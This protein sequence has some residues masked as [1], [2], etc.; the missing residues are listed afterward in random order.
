MRIKNRGP[1]D[2]DNGD[3]DDRP[4]EHEKEDDQSTD[5][6]DLD[7]GPY[8]EETD[9]ENGRVTLDDLEAEELEA[10]ETN[11]SATI[12]VDE[13]SEIKALRRD[14]MAL[15]MD[16]TGRRRDEFVCLACFLVLKK[17]QLVDPENTLCVD[18]A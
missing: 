15:D 14:E 3:L 1:F 12:L 4:N 10:V 8:E 6:G 13:A 7:D 2:D 16:T 11:E 18:C 5:S 17:V 9:G